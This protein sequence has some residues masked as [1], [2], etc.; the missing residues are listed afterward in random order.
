MKIDDLLS[1][2]YLNDEIEKFMKKRKKRSGILWIGNNGPD[3]RKSQAM[4]A[5]EAWKPVKVPNVKKSRLQPFYSFT[6]QPA[7]GG[8]IGGADAGE[9]GGDGGGGGE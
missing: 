4:T 5:K 9:G 1:E 2:N 7:L 8:S 6:G 3:A